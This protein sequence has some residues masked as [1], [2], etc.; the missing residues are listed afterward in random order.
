MK[1]L[2]KVALVTGGGTGIGYAIALEFLKEGASVLITGRRRDALNEAIKSIK[3][4]REQKKLHWPGCVDACPG[5]VAVPED[6][7]KMVSACVSSIS[8]YAMPV[9]TRWD[10]CRKRMSKNMTGSWILTS[11]V[12]F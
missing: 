2:G 9:F 8:W 12:L 1:L 7:E 5:D 11:R 3:S 4:E 6:A 10:L